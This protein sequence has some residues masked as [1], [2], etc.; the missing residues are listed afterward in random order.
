MKQREW[1]AQHRR[2]MRELM[3]RW[4]LREKRGQRS[5]WSA[6]V[7]QRTTL[8]RQKTRRVPLPKKEARGLALG[9]AG[10]SLGAQ[11]GAAIGVWFGGFGAV[12]GAVI[13]GAVGAI[14]GGIVGALGGEKLATTVYDWLY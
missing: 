3:Q 10:G 9:S 14:G 13:G 1:V 8:R 4:G 7:C 11:G 6:Q 2:V 12:P 5:S